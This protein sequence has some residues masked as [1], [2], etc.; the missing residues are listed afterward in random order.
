MLSMD[1]VVQTLVILLTIIFHCCETKGY[2]YCIEM[3]PDWTIR[4]YIPGCHIYD[5]ECV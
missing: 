2:I 1:F 5:S 3:L 4:E